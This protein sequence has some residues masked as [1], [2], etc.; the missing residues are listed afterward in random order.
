MLLVVVYRIRIKFAND[1]AIF[2][3]ISGIAWE[4]DNVFSQVSLEKKSARS[5][6][7]P[8]VQFILRISRSPVLVRVL[9]G[10][11]PL[12]TKPPLTSGASVP[13]CWRWALNLL[14]QRFPVQSNRTLRVEGSSGVIMGFDTI[15]I[16][17]IYRWKCVSTFCGCTMQMQMTRSD[18]WYFSF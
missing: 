17:K 11:P 16:Q 15:V 3:H 7:S 2:E 5:T 1:T 10:R 13:E 9:L 14:L 4:T 18:R 6:H 8:G 12:D